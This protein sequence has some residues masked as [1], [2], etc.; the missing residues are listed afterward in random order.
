MLGAEYIAEFLHRRSVKKVFTVTGG[1]CAFIID[2]IGRHPKID[3]VCFNHEQAAAMAADA[4]WCYKL[5]YRDC[6]LILR[7]NSVHP[8]YGP[9]E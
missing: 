9:S 2:A 6:L 5:N 7:F 3:Y 1:A 4:V 8:Y